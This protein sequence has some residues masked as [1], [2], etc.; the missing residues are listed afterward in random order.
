[1]CLL[2][3][4]KQSNRT[5]LLMEEGKSLQDT[6]QIYRVTTQMTNS[7]KNYVNNSLREISNEFQNE[8]MKWK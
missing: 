5:T 2:S 6:E 1:M 3:L 8:R 4:K 7:W